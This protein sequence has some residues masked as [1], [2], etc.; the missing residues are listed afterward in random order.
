M[1]QNNCPNCNNHYGCACGG[2]SAKA[3]A[4]DGKQVCTKCITTYEL[5]LVAKNNLKKEKNK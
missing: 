4:S 3:T 2:G 5:A 1:S